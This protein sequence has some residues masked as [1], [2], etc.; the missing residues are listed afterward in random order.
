VAA[1][2]AYWAEPRRATDREVEILRRLAEAVSTAL[3]NASTQELARD[4][5][6]A[7]DDMI[8]SAAHELRNA[9]HTIVLRLAT[10]RPAVQ[11]QADAPAQQSFSRLTSMV[12]D[13]TK[14]LESL[15]DASRLSSGTLQLEYEPVELV[16]L[17]QTVMQRLDDEI[18]ASGSA[19][20]LQSSGPV[21]GNWDRMRMEQIATN[22]LCNAIKYGLGK[23][24]EAG[25]RGDQA[26]ATLVVKDHGMG[27]SE[28]DQ[29]SVFA[30]FVRSKDARKLRGVGLG[31]WIVRQLVEAHGGTIRVESAPG[32]GSKFVVVLPRH[33]IESHQTAVPEE[34]RVESLG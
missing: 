17:T 9:F 29:A 34:L 19:V 33:L 6:A 18:Q 26:T 12:N 5:L 4:S 1:L 28:E 25:V 7:R 16:A 22:L 10:L 32:Q 13:A 30:P 2:G 31:L 20:D 15:L 11:K 8:A 14:L 24:I 23:P 27:I 21:D 3:A